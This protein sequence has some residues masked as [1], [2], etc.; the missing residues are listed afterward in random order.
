M[1]HEEVSLGNLGLIRVH[2][3]A[4]E[5][6]FLGRTLVMGLALIL[7]R[8]SHGAMRERR[9]MVLAAAI[10][11]L[12][13]LS[14][15]STTGLF[16]LAC[17]MGAGLLAGAR[18]RIQRVAAV[19]VVGA[20]S[21]IALVPTVKDAL[22]IVTL[23]KAESFSANERTV[24]TKQAKDVF[25]ATRGWGWGRGTRAPMTWRT[26]SCRTSGCSRGSR[27]WCSRWGCCS[28]GRCPRWPARC[29]RRPGR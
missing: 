24:F 12:A 29:A 19:L 25:F 1:V 11:V 16:G 6:S 2:S 14:S 21:I 22:V 20:G 13:I 15:T 7:I 10:V 23:N 18:Y 4:T 8:H 9:R 26:R 17:L 28:A 5:P 3:V 27:A